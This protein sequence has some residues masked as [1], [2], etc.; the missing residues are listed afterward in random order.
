MN[1]YQQTLQ[2]LINNSEETC[3]NIDDSTAMIDLQIIEIQ[4]QIDAIEQGMIQPILLDMTNILNIKMVLY[5]GDTITYGAG[6]GETTIDNFL[7]IDSTSGLT[8]YEYE[9]IK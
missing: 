1:E 7:I 3:E 2:S 8:V 4:K 5:N 6:W 9:G